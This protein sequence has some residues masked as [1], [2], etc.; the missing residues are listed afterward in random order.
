MPVPH[1]A[2]RLSQQGQKRQCRPVSS[3]AWPLRNGV[4]R[5]SNY[6]GAR[7]GTGDCANQIRKILLGD[8]FFIQVVANASSSLEL[9]AQYADLL[10]RSLG[11][12]F[13]TFFDRAP[14]HAQ[15]DDATASEGEG[16]K[17][18][19][20]QNSKET[21]HTSTPPSAP[22]LSCSGASEVGFWG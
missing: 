21:R 20:Q 16:G 3:R 1:R 13:Q 12:S 17:H 19:D 8:G 4:N 18:R 11:R 14:M 7:L 2:D 22:T 15:I 5:C 9:P 6:D 10:G